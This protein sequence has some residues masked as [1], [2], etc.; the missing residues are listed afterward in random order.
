MKTLHLRPLQQ[1]LR[2]PLPPPPHLRLRLL[3]LLLR[4][5]RL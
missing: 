3:P 5:L 2:L 4:Q 1:L